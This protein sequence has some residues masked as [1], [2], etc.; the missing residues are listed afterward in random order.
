MAGLVAAVPAFCM[1]STLDDAEAWR[2]KNSFSADHQQDF[3]FLRSFGS[4]HKG[5]IFVLLLALCSVFCASFGG[6]NKLRFRTFWGRH[7]AFFRLAPAFAIV[8]W[9]IVL[10]FIH[11]EPRES[12]RGEQF[13]LFRCFLPS[14]RYCSP[15]SITM[16]RRRS[17]PI[18]TIFLVYF[19]FINLFDLNDHHL[20]TLK[21]IGAA[22]R[23]RP[24]IGRTPQSRPG[25]ASNAIRDW[26]TMRGSN[27]PIYVIAAQGGGIYASYHAALVL[28]HMTSPTYDVWRR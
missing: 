4:F 27:R 10:Y 9:G 20:V 16:C 15:G 23:T 5:V 17:I 26:V 28:A 7:V 25:S 21:P 1:A 3:E 24:R 18:V 12:A 22:G 11:W 14:G 2:C 13:S 6:D 8:T 19:C